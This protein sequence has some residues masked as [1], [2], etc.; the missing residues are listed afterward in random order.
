MFDLSLCR[1]FPALYFWIPSAELFIIINKSCEEVWYLNVEIAL[2]LL[3]Q[4]H[5]LWRL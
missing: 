2:E 4:R 5:I 3:R 1:S